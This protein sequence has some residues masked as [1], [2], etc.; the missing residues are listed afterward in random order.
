MREIRRYHLI[1]AALAAALTGC[2]GA[3]DHDEL[4]AAKKAEEFARVALVTHD[5]E[6]GYELVSHSTKRY[7]SLEQFKEAV[8]RLHPKGFP[9]AVA[10]SEY[11]PMHGEKAIYIFLTGENSGERFYYRIT[12]EGTAATGYR[13]LRLDRGSDPYPASKQRQKF[14]K[15]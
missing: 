15:S 2:T 13:V 10:A 3:V 4:L 12:M 6:K 14:S 8:S 1:L 5:V 9:G 11:E 7:V